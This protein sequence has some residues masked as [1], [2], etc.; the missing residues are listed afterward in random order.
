MRRHIV[1]H[2]IVTL[3]PTEGIHDTPF[4]RGR[5]PTNAPRSSYR[6][7]K[8]F[9]EAIAEAEDGRVVQAV[10]PCRRPPTLQG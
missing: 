3:P 9:K 4:T 2:H 8:Q 5:L 6:V 7:Q 10:D 1:S